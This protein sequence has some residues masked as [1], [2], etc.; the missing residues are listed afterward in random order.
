MSDEKNLESAEAGSSKDVD[1]NAVN[2]GNLGES[3]DTKP[4]DNSTAANKEGGTD[5]GTKTAE[6]E[7]LQEQLKNLETKLGEQGK[8]LGDHRNFY[9]EISPLMEKL[10]SKPELVDAIMQD[11]ISPELIKSVAE[12]K[13]STE[14]A[15]TVTEAHENVK[16][17]LGE[18]EYEKT[19]P[20]AIKKL[21]EEKVNEA[22][23]DFQKTLSERDQEKNYEDKMK[24]FISNTSDFAEY[25]EDINKYVQEHPD[26]LDITIAYD[27][28]KGKALQTKY[29][30]QEEKDAGEA[31]KEIA[32][33]AGGGAGQNSADMSNED[34]LDKL[35]GTTKDPNSIF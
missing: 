21:I 6:T 29:K 35:I 28:V 31:A 16:K 25:A 30:E 22:R 2:M 11:K 8:E 20:E 7:A 1:P 9:D 27:A 15:K 26:L 5:E 3:T 14:D 32:A 33:N 19:S 24:D 10:Q 23:S 12:G 18:K 17:D 4:S 34:L 13:V